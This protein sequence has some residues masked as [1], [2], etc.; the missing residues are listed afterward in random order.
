MDHS[1]HHHLFGLFTQIIDNQHLGI[2]E[3]YQARICGGRHAPRLRYPFGCGVIHFLAVCE[4]KLLLDHILDE[5]FESERE[6]C[7][8]VAA[9]SA[10]QERGFAVGI[11]EPFGRLPYLL[12]CLVAEVEG[13][14]PFLNH[15]LP[16]CIDCIAG[17][18]VRNFKAKTLPCNLVAT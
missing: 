16:G 7:L 10:E 15:R 8:A 5:P 6:R 17:I 12:P 4:S 9:E 13:C 18:L 2:R 1:E 11:S 3:S 14:A